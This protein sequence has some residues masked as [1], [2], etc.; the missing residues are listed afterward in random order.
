MS[1]SR[2][3]ARIVVKLDIKVLIVGKPR[4][5][6][7]KQDAAGLKESSTSGLSA[8][9]KA[10]ITVDVEDSREVVVNEP[11][12]QIAA[13]LSKDPPQV[14]VE[15][16]SPVNRID[17]QDL[18]HVSGGEGTEKPL[19]RNA[20]EEQEISAERPED[21]EDEAEEIFS[22]F[23]PLNIELE[24]RK[25]TLHSREKLR[26]NDDGQIEHYLAEVDEEVDPLSRWSEG[27]IDDALKDK[28]DGFTVVKHKRGRKTKAERLKLQEG[29]IPRRSPRFF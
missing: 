22:E 7:K 21:S 5:A 14:S 2:R 9:E 4:I 8:Q 29:L 27:E 10:K 26:I 28:S 15:T 23:V 16:T 24:P 17:H 12:D 11:N 3:I 18:Q 20:A 13:L 6:S 19:N 1:M 25:F